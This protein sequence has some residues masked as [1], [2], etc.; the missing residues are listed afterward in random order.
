MK[1][2]SRRSLT[3]SAVAGLALTVTACS[4]GSAGGGGDGGS[5]GDTLTFL[6]WGGQE[7]MEPVVEA[8]EAEHPDIDVEV[9]YAPPVAEY[10]QAL[11]TRVL[12][13]TAPD[14]FVIAA[15]NKT[16]LIDGG[17][18]VDLSAEPWMSTIPEFNQQT[19]GEDGAVYGASVASWGAGIAYNKE[20]LAQVGADSVPAT[21]DEF[22][23]LCQDLK[24]AGITPYLEDLSGM[25]A[26]VA[27]FVGAHDAASGGD[28]D[29]R[30]FD[31]KSS[32]EEE[33]TEPL[34]QYNRLYQE[35]LG[36]PNAVGLTADQVFDEFANGRV[37][38]TPIGPWSVAPLRE[39][40]P[41]MD[42]ALA[43]VPAAPGGEP[44]LVGAA[45]PGY[46]I[47]ATS[48]KVD[49]AK[50]FIEYLVSAEGVKRFQEL[51]S[52]ITVTTDY[53][54]VLDPALEPIV[55][56]VQAGKIYLPQI[57]WTRAEDVLNVEAVAQIQQMVRGSVTPQE[58]AAALD[59]KL[60]TS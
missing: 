41:D 32:F 52:D 7:V 55:S 54:P 27:S 3:M 18:V 22:L 38:M 29:E 15:E 42:F 49:Q 36:D 60:A 48:D 12:S 47:N 17:H 44:F 30:I 8:F 50:T 10:I 56:D 46:A 35:G 5:G 37:A 28:M 25:P 19:Y 43:P 20:L 40:A 9:S 11:Q 23:Q 51:S 16:N 13:G 53:E 39:A 14:V 2:H 24:D 45:S 26:I 1:R 34:T 6:S 58:V 57:A 4:G 21:W 31:G 59:R 33:W